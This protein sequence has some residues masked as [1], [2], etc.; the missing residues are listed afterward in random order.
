MVNALLRRSSNGT[1]KIPVSPSVSDDTVDTYLYGQDRKML[2]VLGTE[3][4]TF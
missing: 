3:F 4:G 2:C 1:S